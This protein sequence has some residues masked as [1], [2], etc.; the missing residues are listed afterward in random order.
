MPL[1]FQAQILVYFNQSNQ[2]PVQVQPVLTLEAVTVVR[3]RYKMH[4]SEK[5]AHT[6]HQPLGGDA[7]DHQS[8]P[9]LSTAYSAVRH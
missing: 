7:H 3:V 1:F 5:I 6:F 8:P 2:T 9:Q 4:R